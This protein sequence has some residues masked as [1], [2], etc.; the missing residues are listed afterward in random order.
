[1]KLWDIRHVVLY[2]ELLS[3]P[4]WLL[5][6]FRKILRYSW[7]S[8]AWHSHFNKQFQI[9]DFDL[10]DF[11]YLLTNMSSFTPLLRLMGIVLTPEC[12]KIE[13]STTFISLTLALFGCSPSKAAAR[14]WNEFPQFIAY[15]LGK[16][17]NVWMKS[18]TGRSA[19][20]LLWKTFA[21]AVIV[22]TKKNN[23]SWKQTFFFEL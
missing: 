20:L 1:M 8:V 6:L 9:Y 4:S 18:C 22:I 13:K 12:L 3:S 10:S 5:N 16:Q 14:K 15:L 17:K 7:W 19:L 2:I 21:A 11:P 23:I